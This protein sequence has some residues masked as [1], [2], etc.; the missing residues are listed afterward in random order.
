MSYRGI[1]V[2]FVDIGGMGGG[3]RGGMCTVIYYYHITI[4]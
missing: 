4:I 1:G 3:I 2:G